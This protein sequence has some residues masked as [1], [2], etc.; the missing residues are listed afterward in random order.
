VGGS[1]LANDALGVLIHS[2]VI[3]GNASQFD[4]GGG[5]SCAPPPS[6]FFG[7]NQSPVFSDYED[8]SIGGNLTVQ[9]VATCWMGIIRNTIGGT[10]EDLSNSFTDPDANEVHTNQ[11]GGGI[12]CEGNSPQVQFGDGH[13]VQNRVH[14]GAVGECSFTA[15]QPNPAPSG[16]LQ[17]ISVQA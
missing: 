8:N 10:V 14:G 5:R 9:D 7:S 16:P 4:G 12:S 6:G 15:L 2:S 11:I 1:V 3:F 17:P 13:A